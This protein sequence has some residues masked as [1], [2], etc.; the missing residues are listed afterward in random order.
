M[1]SNI[2]LVQIWRLY[3]WILQQRVT[4]FFLLP[5]NAF[6]IAWS[7]I[8]HKMTYSS[9]RSFSAPG[10]RC[11]IIHK[12]IPWIKCLIRCENGISLLR[13]LQMINIGAAAYLHQS[14]YSPTLGRW[15]KVKAHSFTMAVWWG[16]TKKNITIWFLSMS[17]LS[18][19]SIHQIWSVSHGFVSASVC[20]W[21]GGWT[22]RKHNH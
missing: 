9:K 8:P 1:R 18:K 4:Y 21:V 12:I 20:V 3:N 5:L 16:Q 13:P 19:S 10:F 17:F 2:L 11:R 6:A 22:E 15:G 14:Q 7:Q